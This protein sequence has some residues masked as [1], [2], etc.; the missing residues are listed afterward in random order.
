MILSILLVEETTIS[1]L[2]VLTTIAVPVI[3]ILAAIVFSNLKT[4]VDK[5]E[6]KIAVL[7]EKIHHEAVSRAE[8]AV[9]VSEKINDLKQNILEEIYAVNIKLTEFKKHS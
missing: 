4:K 1:T 7:E 5:L 9:V 2:W 8:T 3:T 6:E